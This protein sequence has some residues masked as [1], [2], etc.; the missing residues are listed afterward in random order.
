MLSHQAN[1]PSGFV[2]RERER[3]INLILA[4]ANPKNHL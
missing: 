3:T 2:E 1:V 4:K